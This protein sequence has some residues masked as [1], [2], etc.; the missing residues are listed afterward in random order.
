MVAN[1]PTLICPRND[2]GGGL[3][4]PAVAMETV[5]LM[6]SFCAAKPDVGVE[7]ADVVIAL[8]VPE[9]VALRVRSDEE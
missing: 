2:G 3:V 7:A 6:P 4:V 8:A 9:A 5:L 1:R